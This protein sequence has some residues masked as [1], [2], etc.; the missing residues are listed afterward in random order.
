MPT[1]TVLWSWCLVTSEA[2]TKGKT[3]STWLYFSE[4]A[5]FGANHPLSWEEAKS[6]TQGGTI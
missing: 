5:C 6:C 2:R 3:V 4:D 1:N